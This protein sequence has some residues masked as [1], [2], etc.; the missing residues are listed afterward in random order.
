LEVIGVQ[1]LVA[2]CMVC[3]VTSD[4]HRMPAAFLVFY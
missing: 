1:L 4:L 3:E 2:V